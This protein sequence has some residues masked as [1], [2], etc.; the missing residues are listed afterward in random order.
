MA[1]ITRNFQTKQTNNHRNKE[2]NN[3]LWNVNF[4][5]WVLVYTFELKKDFH[6]QK[7]NRCFSHM[8]WSFTEQNKRAKHILD[9]NSSFFGRKCLNISDDN[10]DEVYSTT[11]KIFEE[12]QSREN[13]N[14]NNFI[15]HIHFVWSFQFWT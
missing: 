14:N 8:N 15:H 11:T 9:L 4:I 7:R 3:S 6:K 5:F 10:N 12:K 1:I 2:I 13:N